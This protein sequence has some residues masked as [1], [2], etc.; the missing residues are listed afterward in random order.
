MSRAGGSDGTSSGGFNLPTQSLVLDG[1][2]SPKRTWAENG[3]FQCFHSAR[4]DT[5]SWP[6]SFFARVA[7]ALEGAAR[8]LPQPLIWTALGLEQLN[9]LARSATQ[10]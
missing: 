4:Q 1:C 2:P 3:F 9:S 8:H 5:C 7:V 10:I 6:Q